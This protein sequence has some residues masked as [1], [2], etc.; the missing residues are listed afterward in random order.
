MQL[1]LQ[2]A[3][4]ASFH[5]SR[6]SRQMCARQGDSVRTM[7]MPSRLMRLSMTT[8][9]PLS[10]RRRAH[11]A[12]QMAFLTSPVRAASTSVWLDGTIPR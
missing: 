9:Q 11:S 2:R 12:G 7:K 1:L 3:R 6:S 8:A 10:S 4:R 5:L